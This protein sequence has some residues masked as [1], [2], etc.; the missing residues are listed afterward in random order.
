M[1]SPHP[2][3]KWHQTMTSPVNIFYRLAIHSVAEL[4]LE[5]TVFEL[6]YRIAG[7]KVDPKLRINLWKI[8][9]MKLNTK[10]AKIP[11]KKHEQQ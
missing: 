5:Q 4:T 8:R 11:V 6:P 9:H 7:S 1:P 2:F 3:I 10:F